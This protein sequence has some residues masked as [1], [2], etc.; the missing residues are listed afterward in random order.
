[1]R[2][3]TTQ[4]PTRSAAS[5]HALE[6]RTFDRL[7]LSAAAAPVER[8]NVVE[9]ENGTSASHSR[10]GE[11]DLEAERGLLAIV[12]FADAEVADLGRHTLEISPARA[13]V[14]SA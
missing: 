14:L 1:M 3:A 4:R 11:A 2:G 8:V 5:R 9:H 13:A 6:G 7:G 12:D 10:R